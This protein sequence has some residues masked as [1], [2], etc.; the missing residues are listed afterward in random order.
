MIAALAA[1]IHRMAWQADPPGNH[2]LPAPII[3]TNPAP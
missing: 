3:P 1:I 2:P